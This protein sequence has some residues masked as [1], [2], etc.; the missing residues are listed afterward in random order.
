MQSKLY[1][2][3]PSIGQDYLISYFRKNGALFFLQ[4]CYQNWKNEL[5]VGHIRWAIDPP[6]TLPVRWPPGLR[7][8]RI[9]EI[10]KGGKIP[11][12]FLYF[13]F[14]KDLL[15]KLKYW[16]LVIEVQTVLST[17]KNDQIDLYHIFCHMMFYVIWRIWQT[18]M[19]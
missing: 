18:L 4:I 2:C 3:G 10:N 12:L 9:F 14:F 11:K 1:K 19:T 6:Q 15:A 7:I 5:F 16:G 17:Y 13:L 8:Q